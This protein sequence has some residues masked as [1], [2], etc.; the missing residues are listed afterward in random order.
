MRLADLRPGWHTDFVLHRF[1]AEVE[2]QDD[3]LVVRELVDGRI[4]RVGLRVEV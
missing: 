4:T 1:G 2:E 3:C